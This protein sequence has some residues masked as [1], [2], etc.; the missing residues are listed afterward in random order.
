MSESHPPPR[1]HAAE[2]GLVGCWLVAPEQVPGSRVEHGDFEQPALRRI[3]EAV[4]MLHD[5]RRLVEAATVVQH[6]S[7][8]LDGP[9][10]EAV[11]RWALE[12]AAA[13]GAGVHAQ[14][15]AGQ[16]RAAAQRRRVFRAC[17]RA[18]TELT[19]PG[20][21]ATDLAERLREELGA[22]STSI[23]L[24]GHVADFLDQAV[25]E[26]VTPR[27]PDDDSKSEL[28]SWGIR[29]LDRA[30]CWIRPGSFSVIAA[31]P[32]CGK[33]TLMRQTA[34]RL[35]HTTCRPV[36]Y[37]TLEQDPIELVIDELLKEAVVKDPAGK[38]LG[39]EDRERVESAALH[40]ATAKVWIPQDFPNRLG[41]LLSWL[42]HHIA[43][44]KPAAVFID[45]LTLIEAPGK[46]TY[47]RA[48]ITSARLRGIARTTRTPLIVAAQLNRANVG[49][50]R[51]PE[52]H[53]LRD[54][55]QIEQDATSVFLLHYPWLQASQAERKTGDVREGELWLKIAKYRRGRA[56][57]R[58]R[59]EFEG[60]LKRMLACEAQGAGA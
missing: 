33:T 15:W 51:E 19:S 11:Q 31:R 45:Y 40:L 1:D 6:A 35:A 22:T 46:T 43:E 2:V 7:R 60:A 24:R 48:T 8:G 58:I 30:G 34:F 9:D 18:L 25:N 26:L 38:G 57:W 27:S 50:R 28:L 53:D 55:G 12:A 20:C 5:D 42:Q 59:M 39:G 10:A 3:A 17:Q 47:E 14:H 32:G 23:E 36:I 29:E 13:A 44:H 49:D 4:L 37:L 16:V 52:L 54:S 41:P 56:N 21:D